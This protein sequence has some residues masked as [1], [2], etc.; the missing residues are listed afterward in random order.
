MNGLFNVDNGFFTIM[1]KIWDLICLSVIW[2]VLCLYC[3]AILVFLVPG[4]VNSNI[5]LIL[6]FLIQGITIG[7]ATTALYYSVVK[8]VRRERGYAI[9]SFFQS[10]KLNFKIGA[11]VSEVF[12]IA[13]YV[14]W[15]DFQYANT[16][17]ADG[18]SLGNV[19]LVASLS[20]TILIISVLI[21]IFPVL[22]RFTLSIGGLFKT[23]FLIA[24]R[25]IFTTIALIIVIAAF[26]LLVYVVYPAIFLVPSL[27]CFVMSFLIERVFKKYMPVDDNAEETGLDQWYI[28]K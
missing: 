27:C 22:S 9:R 2:V 12:L 1:G 21:F 23:T 7:P 26:A 6:T 4:S 14:L 19:F 11:I 16:L 5:V 25:H 20:I 10:F 18:K 13:A 28:S 3:F 15:I 17:L 8:V 24:M